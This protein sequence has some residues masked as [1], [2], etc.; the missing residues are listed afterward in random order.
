MV[1]FNSSGDL[2]FDTRWE[3]GER[4]A[5]IECYGLQ[6]TLDGGFVM[7][8]GNGVEAELHQQDSQVMKTWMVFVARTDENGNNLWSG[9]LTEAEHFNL[10]HDAGEYIVATRDGRY[11]VYV[12]SQ[13]WG[14][15]ST[16]GNFALM[17]LD[18]DSPASSNAF[19]SSMNSKEIVV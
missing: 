2:V 19:P 12:D 17:M 9:N 13:T 3:S 8:C 16:G 11:A 18:K 5:N 15:K 10:Q 14:P 6:T 1:G 4:D 7:T